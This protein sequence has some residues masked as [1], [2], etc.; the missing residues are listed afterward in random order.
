MIKI[1]QG[2][3][4]S[5]ARLFTLYYDKFI[6]IALLYVQGYNN[7]EDIVSEVFI[8][9][10]KYA[11]KM[12]DVDRVEAYLYRMVKNQCYDFL[13]KKENRYLTVIDDIDDYFFDRTGDLRLE[14]ECH[15]LQ[16]IIDN[17][18]DKLP[19]KRKVIYQLV[20]D[21]KLSYKEVAE[22]LNIAPKTVENQ[23]GY[24]IKS[25]R[26]V[27]EAYYDESDLNVTVRHLKKRFM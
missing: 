13:K 18:I 22:V 2:D 25:I 12:A 14:V 8:K 21:D 6:H 10:L 26:K 9:I 4:S 7:A 3:K 17:C 23:L 20:K 27:L 16:K 24:A 15:E 11:K 19:P 1:S 5:F